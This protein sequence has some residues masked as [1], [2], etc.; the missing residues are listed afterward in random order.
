MNSILDIIEYQLI[1]L[2]GSDKFVLGCFF[3]L[4][5]KSVATAVPNRLKLSQIDCKR[6]NDRT[7]QTSIKQKMK[8]S[9]FYIYSKCKN[10]ERA[11][12]C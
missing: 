6:K 7:K 11:K 3:D 9:I 1:F 5:L 4:K 10:P 12:I 8:N 2:C